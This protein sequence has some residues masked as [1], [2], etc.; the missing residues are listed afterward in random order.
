MRGLGLDEKYLNPM[1]VIAGI[2][3]YLN[4]LYMKQKSQNEERP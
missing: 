1:R 3:E 4:M 2:S